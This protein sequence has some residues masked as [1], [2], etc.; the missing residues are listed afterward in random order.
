MRS[1]G[2]GWGVALAVVVGVTAGGA[3][4]TASA[5]VGPLTLAAAAPVARPNVVLVVVDTL[6]AD[7]LTPYGWPVP[8]TPSLERLLA[9][10]G[11]VVERAY[12][13]APWTIPAMVG[14]L[15]G[16]WPGEVLGTEVSRYGMPGDSPSLAAALEALGYDTAAFVANPTLQTSG[17]FDRGFATY[18]L[19]AAEGTKESWETAAELTARASAWLARARGARPFFLYVHYVETHD[20]YSSPE[21]VGGHS[22]YFPGY[23]GVVDG[24][25]PQGL[26]LGKLRL[27]DPLADIRHLAALYDSEV[28]WVDRWLG[29]LLGGLDAPTRARTLFAFTADHGEEL[30]DHGG[31]KHGR[32]V[33]DEV[34]RVPLVVRWDGHLPAGT[35]VAGPV[36]SIDLAPTLL[37]AAGG[38]AP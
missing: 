11:V 22:P 3:L 8:T 2:A 35:R 31:W 20:P 17:G 30:F 6:R 5:R 15:A 18:A 24:T 36:R 29:A 19:P 33:Y 4:E 1:A 34:L 10:P 13:A 37:A 7:H 21:L 14:L 9:R 38:T 32:T 25:W 27:L 23:R 12:S 26:M 28:H 16:R